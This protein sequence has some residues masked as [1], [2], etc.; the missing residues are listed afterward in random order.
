MVEIRTPETQQEWD[1]YYDLRY[2]ILREPLNQPR[3]SEKNEGD[4]YGI[5]FALFQHGKIGAIARLDCIDEMSCQARFVAVETHL[6]G[7]GFG[8][9]IMNE[10]ENKGR[11][12]GMKKIV[13]HARDYAVIFYTRL[14][15][16]L[17]E[18]SYKLFDTLQHFLMEKAL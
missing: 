10:L 17:I 15:Y 11:S 13:L 5:H 2:R 1:D 18:P 16:K 4:E 14:D 3:G 8:R 12:L 7:S 6:Q 9:L